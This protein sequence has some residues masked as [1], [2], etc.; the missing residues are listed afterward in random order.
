MVGWERSV[1]SRLGWQDKGADASGKTVFWI[2]DYFE[3]QS[4]FAYNSKKIPPNAWLAQ[5]YLLIAKGIKV[6]EG[7]G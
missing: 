2:K 4:K 7:R 6:G 5:L 3:I 1:Q